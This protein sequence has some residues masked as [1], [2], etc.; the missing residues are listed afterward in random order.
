MPLVRRIP[1][2]GFSQ[3]VRPG[4]RRGQRGRPGAS[5]R[6]RRGSDARALR[7]KSLLKGRY[8]VLKMLGDGELTKPLK[9]AAHRFSQSAKEKI[10][11]AGGEVVV[12]PG[13]SPAKSRSDRRRTLAA[14]GA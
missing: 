8:D 7:A 9:V 11:K 6:R 1:K 10:E 12:L 5:V 13:K 14:T 4:R 3:R 2:R